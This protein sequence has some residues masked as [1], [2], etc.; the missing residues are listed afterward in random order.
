MSNLVQLNALA[1]EQASENTEKRSQCDRL[2]K[3]TDAVELYHTP[4]GDGFATV[5]VNGH[6]E[7]WR[8]RS[9]PFR[10][11]LRYQYYQAYQGSPGSQALQDALGG[12]EAR[13][14]FD[15]QDEQVHLR[16]AGHQGAIYLD[17]TNDRWQVV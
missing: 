2:I 11:W 10:S 4:D 13:A 16:V 8:I 14:Q 17:L 15:G 1:Q 7:N 12:I 9:K 5:Q 6:S 3:L